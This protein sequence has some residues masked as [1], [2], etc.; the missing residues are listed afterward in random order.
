MIFATSGFEVG[1]MLT[2]DLRTN[3]RV[4]NYKRRG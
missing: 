3:H 2:Q 4:A 1:Y